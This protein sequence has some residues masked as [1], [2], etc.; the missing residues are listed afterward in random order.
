MP[1]YN[2]KISNTTFDHGSSVVHNE[3]HSATTSISQETAILQELQKIQKSIEHTEPFISDLLLELQHAIKKR[4]ESKL[5]TIVR[6]LSTGV[7]KS[8][9]TNIASKSLLAFLGI[10]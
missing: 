5:S 6:Q 8:V 2:I 7:V 9:L 4:D 1:D 10:A 3:Y